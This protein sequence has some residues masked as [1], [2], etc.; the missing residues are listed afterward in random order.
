MSER[1]TTGEFKN[2]IIGQNSGKTHKKIQEM[3]KEIVRL[4][5]ENEEL[6]DY[7]ERTEHTIMLA[8][9]TQRENVALKQWVKIDTNGNITPL[10][11]NYVSKDKIKQAVTDFKR[12]ENNNDSVWRGYYLH[13]LEELLEEN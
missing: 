8:K 9:A 10:L 13:K 11:E 5:E 6:K 4:Q 3:A 2:Y 1:E 7:K 12:Q